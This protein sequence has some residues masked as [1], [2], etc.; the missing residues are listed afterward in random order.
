MKHR[1]SPQ[2]PAVPAMPEKL[3]PAAGPKAMCAVSW[4]AVSM[5]CSGVGKSCRQSDAKGVFEGRCVR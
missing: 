4:V 1:H 2:P 3:S 5:P